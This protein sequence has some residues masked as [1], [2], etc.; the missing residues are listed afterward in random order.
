MRVL[1]HGAHATVPRRAVLTR[2]RHTMP[3]KTLSAKPADVV[4]GWYIIDADGEVLG[5]LSTRIADVLRGKGKTN[6]TPHV[7]TGDFVVVINCERVRVTGNKLE[8][9]KYY[10]HSG[11]P[12]GLRERTLAEQLARNPVEV[13]R[14]SVKGM[15]PKNKLGDAQMRKLKI[16]AGSDHPHAAQMPLPLP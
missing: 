11:Y 5:R 3:Q 10:N 9:K 4:H 16:Y 15:I 2:A 8:Q 14:H 13:I 1:I 12:G 7:D 6:F